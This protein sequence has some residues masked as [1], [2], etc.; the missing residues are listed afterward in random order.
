MDVKYIGNVEDNYIIRIMPLFSVLSVP[1]PV[2][3]SYMYTLLGGARSEADVARFYYT[4]KEQIFEREL[5]G[6]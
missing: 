6:Y 3:C 2:C 5:Q 1:I 4:N